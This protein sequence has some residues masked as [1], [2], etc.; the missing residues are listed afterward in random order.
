VSREG[1][2]PYALREGPELNSSSFYVIEGQWTTEGAQ[3]FP[4]GVVVVDDETI[5]R[6]LESSGVV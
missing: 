6:T 1:E 5:S 2:L 4:F 3:E